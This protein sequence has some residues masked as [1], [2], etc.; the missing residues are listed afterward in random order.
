MFP[1]L[2]IILQMMWLANIGHMNKF[3]G[4][5]IKLF[6]ETSN[7]LT[8]SGRILYFYHCNDAGSIY[9]GLSH[10]GRVVQALHYKT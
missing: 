4:N 9:A 3:L 5:N 1:S 2:E 10:A 6:S 7:D 8:F